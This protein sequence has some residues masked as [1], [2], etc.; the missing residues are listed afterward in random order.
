M[1]LAYSLKWNFWSAIN[2]RP[3]G[4]LNFLRMRPLPLSMLDD[5][6]PWMKELLDYIDI[7]ISDWYQL[8]YAF[9][10]LFQRKWASLDV[11]LKKKIHWKNTW[12]E[13]SYLIFN[14]SHNDFFVFCFVSGIRKFLT[15]KKNK[16][17]QKCSTGIVLP[18]IKTKNKCI[19]LRI[20]NYN[21]RE[22]KQWSGLHCA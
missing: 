4:G 15:V 21:Q 19:S 20:R 7:K 3:I 5:I 18:L 6:E 22:L 11:C 2:F 16:F 1:R 12:P 9:L 10:T 14:F 17:K 8:R 13:T